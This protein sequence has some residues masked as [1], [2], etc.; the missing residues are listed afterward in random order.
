MAD[1]TENNNNSSEIQSL[2]DLFDE[3]EARAAASE[4]PKKS[5]NKKEKKQQNTKKKYGEKQ[6][7]DKKDKAAPEEEKVS[8][9]AYKRVML[10]VIPLIFVL[11]IIVVFMTVNLV[12]LLKKSPE[13]EN[14]ETT[15]PYVYETVTYPP[16]TTL[17]FTEP[18]SEFFANSNET[19]EGTG[20]EA[21]QQNTTAAPQTT[22]PSE[23]DPLSWSKEKKLSVL[24]DAVNKTKKLGGTLSVHHTESFT[25]NITECTGGSLGKA[26]A[27]SLM[28]MV[29][30]P[31]DETLNFS[32][33][34]AVNSEG[35]EI[36][37]LLP[38]KGAFSIDSAGVTKAVAYKSGTDTVIEVTLKEE[39]VGVYDVPKYNAGAVGY[40]DVQN[41]DLMGIEITDASIDY[42]GSVI[43][44]KIGSDG[45]VKSAEYTIPL[46]VS[47]KGAKGS[48]SGYAVFDGEQ[49]E[50]WEF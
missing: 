19:T 44:V 29:V 5:A 42:K 8:D 41:F 9:K 18:F 4:K 46:H 10:I 47:G 31:V 21:L 50:T 27:N 30:K 34:K 2:K 3:A 6:N 1:N 24:S 40:L 36:E 14:D 12:K 35:E 33:G 13:K 45:Y 48:L 38:K 32:G 39:I 23:D 28:G 49:R 15:A 22:L 43:T 17:G 25:A 7:T 20:G 11:A 37:I 26:F 16:E